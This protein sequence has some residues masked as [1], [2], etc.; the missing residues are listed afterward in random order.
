[1]SSK[2]LML[3]ALSSAM[4]Q[5]PNEYAELVE[6]TTDKAMQLRSGHLSLVDIGIYRHCDVQG[7]VI[8]LN[9]IFRKDLNDRVCT[10][11]ATEHVLACPPDAG[12]VL[13]M[14]Y[15]YGE[16]SLLE[17]VVPILAGYL[18]DGEKGYVA[19]NW[20]E[21][22]IHNSDQ[23][24]AAP[25]LTL[26]ILRYAHDS[27]ARGGV[28]GICTANSEEDRDATGCYSWEFVRDIPRIQEIQEDGVETDDEECCSGSDDA[29]ELMKVDTGTAQDADSV[30]DMASF[31][32]ASKKTPVS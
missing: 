22:F 17:D 4:I 21:V 28:S 20:E 11:C 32:T 1:M 18:T 15:R 13:W 3:N 9:S 6:S 31:V 5:S 29:V 23:A 7:R 24:K 10:E 30:P 14:E 26:P 25:F 2:N 27:C 19:M 16:A 12:D 8:H